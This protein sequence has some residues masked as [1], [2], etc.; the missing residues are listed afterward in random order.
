MSDV[1]AEALELLDFTRKIR[2][3]LHRNPELGFLEFRTAGIVARELRDLGLEVSTGLAET[4]VVGIVEGDQPGDVV[5]LR[6]DMDALPVEEETGAEY[7]SQV[8]GTMHACGHDGHVAIGLTVARL[9][10]RR[11]QGLA[12]K[13]KLVF[14]PAEEGLGGAERM[15][16]A[17]VLENPRAQHSLA[18][19]LWN[20]KPIGWYGI[21]PGP[22]MAGAD[23]FK[24][25]LYGE[26]GHGAA[27]HRAVDPVT[28]SAQVIS[29]IQT[30]V[31]RNLSPLESAV[32]T[33]A[34]LKAGEAFNVIPQTAE[35]SGTIRAFDAKVRDRV[36]ERVEQIVEGISR[37]MGCESDISIQNITPPVV[38]EDWT[39]E[40]VDRTA[41]KMLPSHHI[42]RAYRSMVSEDMAFIMRQVPGCYFLVGSANPSRHLDYG[43]HHP[44]FDFD[45]DALPW[46]AGLMAQ[47]ALD[48]LS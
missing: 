43:H 24:I 18:L 37:A 16:A 8:A 44:R 22:I 40:S 9:L 19:H 14:Q 3:D 2:R 41:Q 6:F 4:G 46:A 29:A 20:E 15:I 36:I 30:I 32:V 38:N 48:L 35:M 7:A 21:T 5:L 42:D 12:G 31:S 23:I 28:A 25:R 10:S 34:S 13:I 45:E 47:A 33:I 17:G 27:P 39:T 26:G 11:K 1:L